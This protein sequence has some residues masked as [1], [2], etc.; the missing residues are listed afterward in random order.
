VDT[1]YVYIYRQADTTAESVA[2]FLEGKKVGQIRPN[3]YLQVRWPYYAHMMRLCMDLP[4]ANPCQ[5]LVPDAARPNY[6]KICAP[7]AATSGLPTWQWVASSQGDADLNALDKL[8]AAPA[9]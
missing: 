2:I 5:L 4:V 6:L 8:Q 3:E 1:A 7:I 9:K